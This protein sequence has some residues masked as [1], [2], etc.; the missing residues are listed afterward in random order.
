MLTQNVSALETVRAFL[1]A[2]TAFDYDAAMTLVAEDCEY[3]NMPIGKVT[4]PAGVRGVLEPFFSP[5]LENEF[6]VLRELT[7]GKTVFTERLDCHRLETGWV[8]LPI[9]G[10]WEVENGLITT[11]R[12]YFDAATLLSKWPAPAS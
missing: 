9:T 1:N 4:G 7:N 2:L 10:V 12:E 5:T 11:W 8:E 6:R 3:E